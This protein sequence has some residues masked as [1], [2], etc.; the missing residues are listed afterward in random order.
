MRA[1][2][3]VVSVN[4][5]RIYPRQLLEDKAESV[6]ITTGRKAEAEKDR[7]S[8]LSVETLKREESLTGQVHRPFGD[9]TSTQL[10]RRTE[11]LVLQ[12]RYSLIDRMELN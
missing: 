7:N 1:D 6:S 8:A 12:V 10:Q 11:S 4:M 3:I 9:A 2:T 5:L